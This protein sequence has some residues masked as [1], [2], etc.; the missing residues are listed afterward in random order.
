MNRR[1]ADVLATLHFAPTE[2]ARANLLREGTEASAVHVTGNTV[3]D[4][5]L[6][7]RGR[8]RED[9]ELRASLDRRFGFLDGDRPLVLV[10]G[11]RRESFGEGFRRICEALRRL[12]SDG[13]LEILYPVHLNP[14]VTGPVHRLL[15]GVPG[16][17]LIDPVDYP[18]FVYLMDRSRLILTDS[19]GIQEEAPALRR[20]VLVMRGKTERP[21]ALESGFVRLVGTDTDRIVSE[22]RSGIGAEGEPWGVPEN[23]HVFGR[24]DAGERIVRVLEGLGP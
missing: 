13:G 22:A 4:A 21:E 15:D 7:T 1:I 2:L 17:H 20:R 8:I 3:V 9:P 10:T 19:G 14:S 12:A 11:H 5:L 6:W 16:I 24:G 18:S 23:P